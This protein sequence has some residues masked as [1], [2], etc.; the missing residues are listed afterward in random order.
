MP[1][2]PRLTT[3]DTPRAAPVVPRTQERMTHDVW[4]PEEIVELRAEAR[5]AVESRLVPYARD[6]GQREESADSFPWEAFRGLADEGLFAVPF[7]AEIR[8]RTR[9]SDARHLHCHRGDRLP[10]IVDGGR[11]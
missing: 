10:L 5:A 4:L 3:A 9:A 7:G 2:D 1:L 8:P 11:L 6:I